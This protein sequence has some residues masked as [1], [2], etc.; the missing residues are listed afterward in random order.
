MVDGEL[1][2]RKLSQLRQYTDELRQADDINWEKYRSD[3]RSR[4]FVERYLH[5]AIEEVMDISN[6]IISFYQWRE[7]ES[8]RDIFQVLSENGVIPEQALH[9]FQNMASFRNMLVHRYERIED[10][11]VFGIFKKRLSDFYYFI[12]VIKSWLES[13]RPSH[14]TS[15]E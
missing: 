7:P 12:D 10:E 1:I 5:L 9:S 13:I 15:D 6:H 8:F 14:E 3:T 4:A 2:S 11:V